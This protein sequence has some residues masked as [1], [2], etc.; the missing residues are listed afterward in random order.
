MGFVMMKQI[1][2]NV[3]MMA[4]TAV[5]LMLIHNIVMYVIAFLKDM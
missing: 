1:T 4:E 3:I 5:D 2:Y